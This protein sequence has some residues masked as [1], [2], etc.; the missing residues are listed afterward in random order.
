MYF[1]PIDEMSLR[2]LFSTSYAEDILRMSYLGPV[3][4]ASNTPETSPDCLILDKREKPWKIL[5]CEFKH[6]PSSKKDFEQNGKFDIAIVWSISPPLAKGKL[7]E[8]LL[9]QNGC[10]E[11]IVLSDHKAFI[12]LDKYRIP[13]SKEF[14]K[15]DEL[16][17]VILER[18][19][20]TVFA[21]F[22]AARIY[23]KEFEID[24]MVNS[25]S[26]KFPEVRKMHPQGRANVVSA[27]LQTKT[28]L[29][30]WMHG[31]VYCWNDTINANIAVKEIEDIIRT[32]FRKDIPDSD[33][34]Y[35]FEKA[36]SY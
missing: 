13:D 4:N 8:E 23:P 32:R 2:H 14:N 7:L 27:L 29:I 24:K 34:I 6:I 30:R 28:P 10:Q 5:R 16:R 35:S 25:L 33:I 17:S 3:L 15:I 20:P 31:K 21:A 12:N 36:D 22:I 9:A 26:N 18:D 1:Q 19:Y 11:I